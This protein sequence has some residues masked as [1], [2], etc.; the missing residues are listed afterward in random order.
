MPFGGECATLDLS[1]ETLEL[2]GESLSGKKSM[3]HL[4]QHVVAGSDMARIEQLKAGRTGR[5]QS[6]QRWS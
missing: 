2:C 6:R 3:Q 5:T 4:I 1:T